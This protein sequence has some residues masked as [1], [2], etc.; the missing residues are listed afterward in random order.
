MELNDR[1]KKI[2]KLLVDNYIETGEP[3]SSKF[4]CEKLDTHLSSATIRNELNDLVGMGYL[5]QLHTSSGRIPSNAGY[6]EYVDN[7]M[8]D[9]RLT[10]QELGFLN[11]FLNDR[12]GKMNS[13]VNNLAKVLS[14]ATHYTAVSVT[15]KPK[16]G[17]ILK[18]DGIYIN[19]TN[20]YLVMITS[21][22]IGRSSQI[23]T[24]FTLTEDT[25]RFIIDNLNAELSRTEL[26]HIDKQKIDR[27]K[28]KLGEFSSVLQQILKVVHDVISEVNQYDV[29]VEGISNLLNYPEFSDIAATRELLGLLDSKEEL[30]NRLTSSGDNSL[31]IFIGKNDNVLDSSSFIIRTFNIEDKVVGAVGIIGP[32]RMDYSGAIAKLEYVAN[33]LSSPP[34]APD[35]KKE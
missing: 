6:R 10:M 18:F 17:T 28:Y 20:F 16:K 13:I 24:D 32:K 29:N 33:I 26:M 9:Y 35:D 27:L 3:I 2:L 14:A 4:L 30:I 23:W 8:S 1:K 21:L 7:L 34:D 15:T 12:I 19:E 11:K 25:V 5:Q 22:E 31:S